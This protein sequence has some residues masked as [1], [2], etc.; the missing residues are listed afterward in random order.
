MAILHTF[1]L[2]ARGSTLYR[3]QILTTKVNP[4]A[5]RVEPTLSQRLFFVLGWLSPEVSLCLM[6]HRVMNCCDKGQLNI[7]SNVEAMLIQHRRRCA[8]IMPTLSERL[9]FSGNLHS[10]RLI[11][12]GQL[13]RKAEHFVLVPM[14]PMLFNV[15]LPSTTLAHQ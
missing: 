7:L 11:D 4:R 5:V 6:N 12:T 9:L 8:T 2:T 14:N 10:N 15:G 3:R 1:A 13:C